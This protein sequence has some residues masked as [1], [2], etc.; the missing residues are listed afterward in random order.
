VPD[1]RD[2]FRRAYCVSR[3][4]AEQSQLM[5]TGRPLWLRFLAETL[6]FGHSKAPRRGRGCI[7]TTEGLTLSGLSD[8]T[9]VVR[10]KPPWLTPYVVTA[11]TAKIQEEHLAL[12]DS[13][14]KLKALFL[15]ELVESWSE[16]PR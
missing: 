1:E 11:F 5:Q 10:F 13:R 6:P 9:F 4:I 16:L 14:G 15:M 3:S 2:A 8:K 12:F 7:F